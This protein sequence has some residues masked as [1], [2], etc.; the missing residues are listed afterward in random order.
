VDV[1]ISHE[2]LLDSLPQPRLTQDNLDPQNLLS[3]AVFSYMLKGFPSVNVPWSYP[4]GGISEN[5]SPFLT[6]AALYHTAG[7]GT[8]GDSTLKTLMDMEI[9]KQGV[10]F[11]F[12]GAFSMIV[13]QQMLRRE[14]ATIRGGIICEKNLLFPGDLTPAL[15]FSLLLPTCLFVMVMIG[16]S[17]FKDVPFCRNSIA[18][19]A[20]ILG[21]MKNKAWF[22]PASTEGGKQNLHGHKCHMN[23]LVPGSRDTAIDLIA[24]PTS[25]DNGNLKFGRGDDESD[26]LWWCPLTLH[27]W[28]RITAVALCLAVFAVLELLQRLSDHSEGLLTSQTEKGLLWVSVVSATV[29]T[30]I[31][32]L[33]S[34]I[35]S[36]IAL[37]SP[38]H[39]L[40][41]DSGT[42]AQRSIMS[43]YFGSTP[44]FTLWPAFRNRHYAALVSAIGAIIGALLTVVLSG[45]YSVE[46]GNLA[47]PGALNID[48]GWNMTWAYGEAC[49]EFCY[50]TPTDA[51]LFDAGAGNTLKFLNWGNT[52]EP[53]GIYDDLVFPSLTALQDRVNLTAS[54]VVRMLGS[55]EMFGLF[56]KF[57]SMTFESLEIVLPARRAILHYSATVS[58]QVGFQFRNDTSIGTQV[59][60]QCDQPVNNGSIVPALHFHGSYA[61]DLWELEYSAM[62]DSL[63][64]NSPGRSFFPG[65]RPECPSILAAF[66]RN[67]SNRMNGSE[68][69]TLAC[70][71]KIQE[72]DTTVTFTMPN[73]QI[74]FAHPPVTHEE[75]TRWV[76][77]DYNYPAVR[78]L[79]SELKVFTANST[80]NRE[81]SEMGSF[82]ANIV[83]GKHGI[84]AEEFIGKENV[85]RLINATSKMYSRY[86][87]LVMSRKFHQPLNT[88][89]LV[90]Q[91]L[92]ATIYTLR[93]RLVQHSA[94]KIT[95]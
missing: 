21:S 54:K 29:M 16:L 85:P 65:S 51:E 44:M 26:S 89:T 6:L 15:T 42:T 93:P 66:G 41:R 50:E 87:A 83:H 34:S 58:P 80:F 72:V 60:S 35:H 91:P 33:H 61:G 3:N 94:P 19:V 48:S 59:P 68:T 53:A 22:D 20:A 82:F 88:S 17:S 63:K 95:L 77:E 57:R 69:T 81:A 2:G 24:I 71:Q 92:Q 12:A 43:D 27:T 74:D 56:E 37:I 75:T 28:V 73:L 49:D 4:T 40:S 23:I 90:P 9:L 52:S 47:V 25:T 5:N 30:G 1:E 18:G 84:P 45:L 8:P 10:S 7:T 11:T 14:N 64:I 76:T 70:I 55:W 62:Y 31:A 67:G 32:L 36:N 86:M 78:N 79:L 38:Y 13:S 39:E 46:S